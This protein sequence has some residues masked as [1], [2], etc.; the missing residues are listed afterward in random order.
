M[1]YTCIIH[2]ISILSAFYFGNIKAG[3]LSIILC[4]TS[5]NYWQKPLVYSYRRYID[6]L[7]A[8]SVV[9]YHFYLSLFTIKRITCSGLFLVGM[10]MY[11]ISIYLATLQKI[12]LSAICHCLI[13]V[14]CV[15]GAISTYYDYNLQLLC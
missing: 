12:K 1:L 14:F 6:M 4:S 3:I 8:F 2:P 7:A 10:S 5:L 11:P 15:C 9:S 13:H